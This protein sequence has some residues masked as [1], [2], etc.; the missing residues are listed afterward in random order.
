M[1]SGGTLY[2]QIGNTVVGAVDAVEVVFDDATRDALIT[3]LTDGTYW[4]LLVQTEIDDDSQ[5]EVF[6]SM[7]LPLLSLYD[8]PTVTDRNLVWWGPWANSVGIGRARLFLNR[9]S[10]Q[11]ESLGFRV[12]DVATPLDEASVRLFG[13]SG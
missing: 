8:P 4:A 6:T 5:K 9:I 7:Q 10:T 13:V 3:A 11:G 12:F 2:T 1:A